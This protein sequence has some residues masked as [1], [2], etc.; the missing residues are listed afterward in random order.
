MHIFYFSGFR[1]YMSEIFVSTSI[2]KI[3]R[4]NID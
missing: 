4:N 1:F 3:W 2:K